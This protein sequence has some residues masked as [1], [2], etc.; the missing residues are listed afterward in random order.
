[1]NRNRGAPTKPHMAPTGTMS[2]G[3]TYLA[4]V[5]HSSRKAAPNAVL[6]GIRNLLSYP[7]I[8]RTMC[9]HRRPMNP[10]IPA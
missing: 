4:R 7:M 8:R 3:L 5:S 2:M 6:A 1:M 9:G 10:S